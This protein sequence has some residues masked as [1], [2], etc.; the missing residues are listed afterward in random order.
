MVNT[1]VMD[2]TCAILAGGKS[3]RMGRDKATLQ[4]GEKT[5]IR[6]V[7]EKVNEVFDR[8][9]VVSRLHD[10]IEGVEAPIYEDV[11]PFGG[12]VAGIV[13]ALLY[14]ETPYVFILACDMPFLSRDALEY[15]MNEASTGEEVIIPKV[16]LGYE[17]FH[18]I[19]NRS[20]IAHYF[21]LLQRNQLKVGAI[22]PYVSVK[23]LQGYAGF[24]VDG[25][26]VFT[27][28]NTTKD[29]EMVRAG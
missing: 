29:L 24:F 4:V 22:L 28:V 17:P 14:S 15:M 12:S 21:R 13:T 20:C 1:Y 2:F 27:N 10:R 9:I 8:V 11:V 26:S 5:L 18:A 19:Y 3:S 16:P 23:V 25:R 7:Y 6:T